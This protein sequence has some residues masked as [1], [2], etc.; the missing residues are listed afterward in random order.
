MI[1]LTV[2]V[3]AVVTLIL[4]LITSFLIPM[5][6]AKVDA[7]K[8]QTIQTWVMIAVEAAEQIFNQPRMGEQKKAF[9]EEFLMSKGFTLSVD[10]MDSLIEAAV[11]EL[12]SAILE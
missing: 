3:K 2:I 10:E 1:D 5:I 9:V 8:L 11:H 4:A 7:D 12:N 6:K